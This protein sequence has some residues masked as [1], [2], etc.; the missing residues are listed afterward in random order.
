MISNNLCTKLIDT[1]IEYIDYWNDIDDTFGSD[2]IDA[3]IT[4][5]T[6]NV[7]NDHSSNTQTISTTTQKQ[8]QGHRQILTMLKKQQDPTH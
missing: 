8:Q 2:A 1:V 3:V 6:D 7:I 5:I 4:K